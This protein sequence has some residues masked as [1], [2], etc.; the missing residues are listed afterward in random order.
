MGTVIDESTDQPLTNV[1]VFFNGTT[2]G[3]KTDRKGNVKI[4]IPENQKL[5]LAIS[6]IG[7]NSF[8]LTDYPANKPLKIL[9]V[10]RIYELE[11]K[12]E[13]I[14]VNMDYKHSIS[15]EGYSLRQMNFNQAG[16]QSKK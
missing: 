4:I 16:G 1:S 9:L 15:V 7:Y 6:A 3:T 5:P 12:S 14:E 11:L 10:P 2:V 13:T 8:L